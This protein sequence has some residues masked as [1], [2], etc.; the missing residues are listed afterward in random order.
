M[1]QPNLAMSGCIRYGAITPIRCDIMGPFKYF[2][3]ECRHAIISLYHTLSGTLNINDEAIDFTDGTGYIEKDSGTSFPKSY[4]WL[5]SN[6][7]PKKACVM[8]SIAD[9]PFCATSFQGCICVIWYQ[10]KEFRLATYLGV[11][12][13]VCDEKQ[14]ILSQG[15]LLLIA[16]LVPSKSA[17]PLHAPSKGRMSRT[18]RESLSCKAR[19]RF[20]KNSRLVF[21]M[22]SENCSYEAVN[23]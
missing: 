13:I 17:H 20:Y 6:D 19:V 9:I 4:L 22:E 10:G 2:P 16:D 1:N 5:Q 12:V 18:I 15:N 11:R 3:M 23:I 7:F 8:I 21:D 14:V